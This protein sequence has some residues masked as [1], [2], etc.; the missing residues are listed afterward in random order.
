LEFIESCRKFIELESTPSSGSMELAQFAADLCRKAGLHVELQSESH[1]GLDQANV[2]ARPIQLRPSNELLLQTHF[3][4]NDPGNYALWTR[5][6]ANPFNAT[7]Y[8]NTLYGLGAANAKLDFLCKLRAIM[9]LQSSVKNV[10]WRLPFVLVGTFGEEHGMPGAVKL[11]RKKKISA[12]AALV[13]E[14]TDLSLVHAGKGFAAVEIEIPFSEEERDFRAKHDLGDGTTTQSRIFMG[15]AAHS[16]SPE[17]GESAVS[18]MLDYLSK[19]PDGLAVMEIEGG[20]NYN[21]IPAHAILEIDMVGGLRDTISTKIASIIHAISEV[22][23]RFKFFADSEF[24]PPEPTLNIGL[25]RTFEDFV[26]ISGCVRLT[27]SVTH[28]VYVEWMEI[29][30]KACEAVGAVFRVT[31]YKQPF[32]T[33][34]EEPLLKI[35]QGELQKMGL[36]TH[37]GAQSVANEANVFSRFGIASVV[38]GPG[39]GVGNSHAPNEHVKIEDLD[40]AAQFYK[41]VLERVCL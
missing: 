6:G 39:R 1:N 4:T 20:T 37:C 8:Q 30:R 36:P 16:T 22:E 15:K 14:P 3:D 28:E 19:L 11:I 26:K 9:D 40:K 38:I 12:K 17:I 21:T 24:T 29:L 31:D 27:P 35:C 34:L 25:I 18:K 7:I 2:I 41:A 33:S 13:G 5:T 32:K 23:K 10:Q